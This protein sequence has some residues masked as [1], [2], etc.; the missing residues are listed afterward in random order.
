M[1][2]LNGEMLGG[3]S[4]NTSSSDCGVTGVNT[5]IT[6]LPVVGLAQGEKRQASITSL[7]LNLDP[8]DAA[9]QVYTFQA[10]VAFAACGCPCR[11]S[12]D[13]HLNLQR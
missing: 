7:C 6:I 11:Y 10:V 12:F 5:K 3:T 8:T 4:F 9:N 2:V 1:H 13:S